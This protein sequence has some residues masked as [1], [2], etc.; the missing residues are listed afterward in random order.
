MPARSQ[1]VNEPIEKL[2]K[3][4]GLTKENITQVELIG[5]GVRI[6]KIQDILANKLGEDK[7]GVHINGDDC[8]AFGTAYVFANTTKNFKIKKRVYANTGAPYEIKIDINSFTSKTKYPDFCP[9]GDEYKDKLAEDCTRAINKNTT[10]FKIRHGADVTRTV[11]FKHDSD[12]QVKLYERMEGSE[13]YES[14]DDPLLMTFYVYETDLLKEKMKNYNTTIIPKTHLR[15]KSNEAGLI[16]LTAEV[17]FEVDMYL[18]ELKL[19]NQS[20]KM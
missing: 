3:L 6:P 11:S 14:Y 19:L 15:F 9:S 4:S 5:G 7:I 20:G 2:F 16:T 13:L 10:L 1:R 18:K 8:F 12:I 17:T